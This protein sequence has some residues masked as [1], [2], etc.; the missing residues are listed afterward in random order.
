MADDYVWVQRWLIEQN[1]DD[2]ARAVV[3]KLHGASSPSS[4]QAD[5]E[6]EFLSMQRTIRAESTTHTPSLSALTSTPSNR[7]RLTIA[8]A[9]Q[10][11]G[12]FTGINVINY[13]G[14][15]MYTAL[16]VQGDKL[17]LVQ[18][19]YGAVGP[20]TNLVFIVFVLD[21]IGRKKPLLFGAASLTVLFSILAAIVASFP[22]GTDQTNL[23]AQKAGIAII[24]AMSIVF[25]LS[26]GPVSWVLASEIFPTRTRGMG[27][28]VATCC[29]WLLNVVISEVSPI[30]MGHV[31]WKY[32]IP[33]FNSLSLDR[34][35]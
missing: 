14:P 23:G 6:A 26:F 33:V 20:I 21:R 17:L 5:A 34:F 22:P 4:L 3:Y 24:F 9:V 30:G 11:F 15:Q 29:N 13:F 18:G 27:V 31:G 7:L 8:C 12:Q 19:I 25:S 35:L 10:I 2:E 32:V 16:G 28:A 1:R